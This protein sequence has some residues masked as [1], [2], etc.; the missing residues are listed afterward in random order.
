G[1]PPAAARSA[2]ATDP[3]AAGS[4]TGSGKGGNAVAVEPIVTASGT[5]RDSAS[6]LLALLSAVCAIGVTIAVTRAIISKRIIQAYF[7]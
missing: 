2:G 7:A 6:G 3:V 5:P 1:A 4:P